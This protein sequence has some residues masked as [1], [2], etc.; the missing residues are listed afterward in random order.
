MLVQDFSTCTDVLMSVVRGPIIT[1]R[2]QS[3]W[4]D[5]D[6]YT[7]LP[8]PGHRTWVPIPRSITRNGK[9]IPL[10][11]D[12]GLGTYPQTWTWIP[13]PPWYG[14]CVPT[15]PLTWDLDTYTSSLYWTWN[16]G[17]YPHLAWDLGA[18]R[19]GI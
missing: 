8:S 19:Y 4:R 6:T 17:T 15:P 5:L 1:A 9:W 10:H 2:K 13:T 3:C 12:M 14:T 7:L 16:L 11:P 18:P